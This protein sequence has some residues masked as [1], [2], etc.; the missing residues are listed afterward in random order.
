MNRT[1]KYDKE[2]I[3]KTL[4]ANSKD[5][6]SY[7]AKRIGLFG[8]YVRDEQNP[9]SDIDFVVEFDKEKKAIKILFVLLI[10]FRICL[11]LK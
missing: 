3:L 1:M 11:I 4:S 9:D 10:F 6:K 2:N 7:G 8:S 5:I